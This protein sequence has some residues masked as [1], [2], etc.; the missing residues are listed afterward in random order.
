MLAK[1]RLQSQGVLLGTGDPI[2]QLMVAGSKEDFVLC[3]SEALA[4]QGRTEEDGGIRYLA[5]I[6]DVSSQSARNWLRGKDLPSMQHA[7][8]LAVALDVCVEWL[9]TRRGPKKPLDARTLSFIKKVDRL[10][11]IERGHLEAV[12]DS[13]AKSAGVDDW[14]KQTDRRKTERRGDPPLISQTVQ[15]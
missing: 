7:L 3:L 6:A 12:A 10:P 4:D 8:Q 11:Y 13:F 15:H 1:L 5:N 14:D 9:L 2:L